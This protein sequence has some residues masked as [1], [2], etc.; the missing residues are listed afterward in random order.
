MEQPK[1]FVDPKHLDHVYR[2]KKALYGL[3]QA[4]R[5]WY[6]ILSTHLLKKGYTRRAVDKTL[7]VKRIKKDVMIAQ[8]YVDNI[9]FSSTSDIL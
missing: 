2:L 6:E 8:V 7:F 4:L 9:M 5:A 1:G 3:K